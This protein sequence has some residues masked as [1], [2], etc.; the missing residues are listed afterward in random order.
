M[1]R[2]SRAKSAQTTKSR[3]MFVTLTWRL[4]TSCARLYHK[5]NEKSSCARAQDAFGEGRTNSGCGWTHGSALDRAIL[6]A[7]EV[8]VSFPTL[9]PAMTLILALG[10]RRGMPPGTGAGVFS[11][12]TRRAEQES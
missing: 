7:A 5:R 10:I 3:R 2:A 6:G 9:L 4:A 12:Q 8:I 1:V 11:E